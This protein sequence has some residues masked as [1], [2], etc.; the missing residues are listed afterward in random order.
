M[1]P[2]LWT[3]AAMAIR[4]A[5]IAV[6]PEG[7]DLYRAN[8]DAY[9]TELAALAQYADTALSSVPQ[10]ARVLISAHDAFNYFGARH[11]YEVLGIQGI[12]TESEAGL[13]RIEE[14]VDLLVS[15]DIGAVF[16]ES[17]VSD[18]NV[19]ALIEGA[20]AQGHIVQIGGELFSD[21][22]GPTGSYEGT[23]LGMIDHN[24]TVIAR[25]LGGDVPDLGRLGQLEVGM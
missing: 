14:L 15:R 8:A 24:A 1:D 21:A 22:M 18:R 23:Y 10:S 2:D 12:S 4:D 11:G 16:V 6:D 20:A 3:R 19:R 13:Q 5:L 9:T 25:A 17:S 7:A